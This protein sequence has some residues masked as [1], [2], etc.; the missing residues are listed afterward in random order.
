[1]PNALFCYLSDCEFADL[2]RNIHDVVEPRQFN[3]AQLP[4]YIATEVDK[5][6]L[7]CV[8]LS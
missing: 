7:V 1:M 2:R 3:T 4:E 6:T 5:S 8:R